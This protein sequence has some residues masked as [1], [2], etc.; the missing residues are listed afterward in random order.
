MRVTDVTLKPL[1][2]YNTSR[3]T[4]NNKYQNTYVNERAI[5]RTQRKIPNFTITLR[6]QVILFVFF[7]FI[8]FF[9]INQG[10]RWRPAS[11]V[12]D[13]RLLTALRSGTNL[14][15]NALHTNKNYITIR[16]SNVAIAMIDAEL[17][18]IEWTK[19]K[20]RLHFYEPV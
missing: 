9:F 8:N 3:D 4:S 19:K 14:S 12:R 16:L 2:K 17:F 5:G 10:P 11:S 1:R 18:T 20:Y 7:F 15:P 13:A 6:S